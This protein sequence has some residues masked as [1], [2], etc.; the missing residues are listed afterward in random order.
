LK[1]GSL[2][3]F[4][5]QDKFWQ[6]KMGKPIANKDFMLA[7]LTH[8]TLDSYRFY[9]LDEEDLVRGRAD[10]AESLPADKLARVEFATQSELARDAEAGEIDILHQ[11]DFTYH[12]PYLMEYRA[13]A[14]LTHPFGIS[15]AT[16]SLDGVKIQSR[17]IDM[18]LAGPK[19]YDSIVCTSACAKRMVGAAFAE[20]AENFKARFDATLPAP[21]E[22]VQIPLGIADDFAA[23][24]E[25]G[26]CRAALGLAE[27]ELVLLCLGRFSARRKMDLGP[28]LESLQYLKQTGGLSDFTLILAGGGSESE[29]ALTRDIVATLGLADCVRIEANHSFTRK[30]ELYGAA[31]IFVSLVDN[32]QETF[33]LTVIEAMA[34]GLPAIV[35]EFNGY[36]E[37]VHHGDTGFC[38]PTYASADEAPWQALAGVLDP[39]LLGFYRGQKV[40]FDFRRF[41]ESLTALAGNIALRRDM[42]EKAKALSADYLW[43]RIIPRYEEMWR[44]Q[45]DAALTHNA[46]AGD[47]AH[48]L[49]VPDHRAVFG[50]YPTK[51]LDGETRV[52]VS[53]YCRQRVTEDFKPV[54][55]AAHG[56]RIRFPVMQALMSRLAGSETP[57]ALGVLVEEIARAGNL[58]PEAVMH[59]FDFLLKHGYI[60]IADSV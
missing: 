15:G 26:R 58:A 27:D 28:M 60:D 34:H 22:L 2:D 40:A 57:T 17:L 14:N 52:A 38:V 42:G 50:H 6:D 35:S 30:R 33:G 12:A 47:G 1:W 46:A 21:P 56:G 59:N 3:S 16:H 49:L 37:L 5:V 32:Y 10:L 31:D 44:A 53:D 9:Y 8:G 25:R 41:A 18:L 29:V 20:I 23:A 51:F 11:G 55:Y 7:L 54:M 39:S 36:R 48:P 45:H 13:G 24:P 43:P 4:L 19:P